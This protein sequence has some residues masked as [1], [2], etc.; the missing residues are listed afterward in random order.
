MAGLTQTLVQMP[1]W[2]W[3]WLEIM[4][5][6][7]QQQKTVACILFIHMQ[8]HLSAFMHFFEITLPFLPLPFL[9][10]FCTFISI[11]VQN[12]AAINFK[13]IV[14]A[15]TIDI[16]VA[17][18]FATE[19]RSLPESSIWSKIYCWLTDERASV[20]HA[21]DWGFIWKILDKQTKCNS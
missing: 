8:M 1:A 7:Q 16:V 20:A 15:L 11:I 14:D 21:F 6:P 10:W 17:L 13:Q 9:L 3:K 2:K 12:D 5:W 19:K 4:T 18:C